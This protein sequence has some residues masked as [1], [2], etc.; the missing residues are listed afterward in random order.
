M[1]QF[2]YK[3]RNQSGQVHTGM[4]EAAS[5]EAAADQLSAMDYIPVLIQEQVETKAVESVQQYFKRVSPQDLSLF[6]RQLS[7]LLAASIPFIRSLTVV[8]KQMSG[9]PYF[10][11][12]ISQ[13]RQDVSTGTSFSSA[14]EKYPKIFS[15][16]YVNMVSAAETAGILDSVLNRLA[17]LTEHE[18]ETRN[19]IKIA[20][21]YPLIVV[22]SICVAF[23]FLVSFVIPRFASLY[24]QFKTTL[25]LPT[26]ILIGINYAIQHY[27]YLIILGIALIIW[28]ALW[29]V[30][31]PNGRW[32]WDGIKLRLPIFGPLFQKAALSRFARVF[33]AMQKSGLSMILT[34]DIA[35][36]TLDNAVLARGVE[37]IREGVRQGKTIAEP[38]EATGLFP[39]LI[40]QMIS[41]GEETAQIEAMLS[42]VSDYYDR[43]VD[44]SVRNLSSVVEPVLLLFVGGMV[45]FLALGIFLPMWSMIT[46]FRH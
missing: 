37:D 25:P 30:R 5:Q 8:E 4:I 28:A 15:S 41:V 23:V 13:I 10:K 22:L 21:R 24:S 19:R 42:K 16:L 18:M 38:M 12:I 46:L 11:Q 32:Q 2:K 1:A 9:N 31:T 20:V 33:G 26:R 34:L 17:L 35:A 6:S 45:L 7:T 27:W 36:K 29:Y 14:L 39:P 44:Y 3:V 40:I 43:D